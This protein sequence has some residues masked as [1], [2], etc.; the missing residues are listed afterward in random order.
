MAFA[1]I[2]LASR[3]VTGE[4]DPSRLKTGDLRVAENADFTAGNLVQKAG[5]SAKINAVAITGAPS[6]ITGT[7]WIPDASTTRRVIYT[8]AGEA[9]KDDMTG[10][11][12]TSLVSGLNTG[13][14]AQ[15]IEAGAETAGNNRKLF[16]LTG[17]NA[18]KVLS[19]DAATM[20][21]IATPHGDWSG[22]NQPSFGFL[23][24]NSLIVGGNVNAP[25]R[26]Y[27]SDPV[28]HE[29][30]TAANAF[31]LN[32]YP[33]ESHKLVGGITSVSR[34]FLWKY[35]FGVYWVNDAA[36]A[37]TGWFVQPATR[38][39]GA[40]NSPHAITQ[41]D[42]GTVAFLSN[43]GDVVL[44]QET[45][46]SLSGVEFINLSKA[47]NLRQFMRTYFNVNRLDRTQLRWYEDKKELHCILSALGTTA[48]NRRLVIDFNEE[49]TRVY[50]ITKDIN[51]S[52]WF[53]KDADGIF[54]P[55]IG[56]NA[57]FIRATDQ[58]TRTVDAAAY[59]LRLESVPSDF[60]DIDQN[61]M[62]KKLFY[63]LHMEFEPSGDYDVPVDV[64]VDGKLI[65]TV[66]FNQAGAGTI[67][68]FTLPAVLGNSSLRRRQ[69]AIAGEGYY[70]HLLVRES[71]S[72]NPQLARFWVEF[73]PLTPAR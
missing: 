26:V 62:V 36:S 61:F 64:F 43:A 71:T 16:L 67:F 57:G 60:S 27:G 14:I 25:H 2:L 1:P 70:I 5:G 49:R 20:N 55:V 3:G 37:V 33:G 28:N 72:N 40:A 19:G 29:N 69:R 23:F 63:R 47:L 24:R 18:V 6:I 51:V 45:S 38:Q 39:F 13:N 32:V 65:G 8:S 22:T 41:V 42:Q 10:T 66:N 31:T 7:E 53:E 34:A 11:F 4:H 68:P 35:P 9:L 21:N 58:N 73:D 48:E 50:T 12:A 52:M 44:M 46:G 54:R 17:N 15:L 56:D 30:F 59:T